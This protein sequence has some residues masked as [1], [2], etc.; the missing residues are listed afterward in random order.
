[1]GVDVYKC[2]ADR[3][4]RW[5]EDLYRMVMEGDEVEIMLLKLKPGGPGVRYADWEPEGEYES[6]EAAGAP[7]T[8]GPVAA[9]LRRLHALD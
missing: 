6:D 8:L 2:R 4:H 3:Q 1:M 5:G 7:R 9:L